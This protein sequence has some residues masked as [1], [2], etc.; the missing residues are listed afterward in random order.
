MVGGMG[1][2]GDLEVDPIVNGTITES[3]DHLL[4]HQLLQPLMVVVGPPPNRELGD[5]DCPDRVDREPTLG[6]Y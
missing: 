2:T 5:G 4:L 1:E 6:N 3:Q